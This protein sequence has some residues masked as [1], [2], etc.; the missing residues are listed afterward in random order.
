MIERTERLP[1]FA[2]LQ[3]PSAPPESLLIGGGA[4]LLALLAAPLAMASPAM[5]LAA[6]MALVLAVWV[7]IRPQVAAYVLLATTPLIVGMSRGLVLPGLRPSEVVLGVV[8]APVAVRA[9][10]DA[11]RSGVEGLRLN[12]LDG[13]ITLFAATGS[14]VPVAW[15]VMRGKE[16]TS[17]DLLYGLQLWKYYAVFLVIR[18]AIRTEQEVRRC[19]WITMLSAGVVSL[20]AILQSV[21][22]FGVPELLSKHYGQELGFATGERGTSTIASSLA[23]ADVM[24]ISV[25]IATTW[26]FRGSERRAALIALSAIFVFGVIAAGQFSGYIGFAIAVLVVGLMTGSLTRYLAALVPAVAV[27]AVALWSVIARRLAGFDEDGGLP[28]SWVGRLENLEVYFWPRLGDFNWVLGVQPSARVAAPETWRDWVFIESGHTWLLWTGGV[29]FL[30]AYLLLTWVAMRGVLAVA[31]ERRD[32]IG[33]AA[34]ASLTSLVVIFVL[35]TFDPHISVRGTAE[36]TFSLL[37][38][39]LTGATEANRRARS[40]RRGSVLQAGG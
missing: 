7:C 27:G 6:L 32:A 21:Q 40:P 10:V 4:I 26:L 30:I 1:A 3:R 33:T 16:V 12:R 5:V 29:P 37:A 9:A 19:L 2:R 34:V 14:I 38:L 24:V 11:A 13:A 18:Y 23:V 28:H 8:A 39:A 22:L 31:R 17:D 15:L 35:M 36:L 25:A 20:V